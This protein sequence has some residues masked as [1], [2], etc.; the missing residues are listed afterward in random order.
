MCVPLNRHAIPTWKFRGTSCLPPGIW[1]S[2]S[3]GRPNQSGESLHIGPSIPPAITPPS[4]RHLS[5]SQA[6]S[7][8]DLLHAKLKV[9]GQKMED[10]GF[11]LEII[12]WIS[13]SDFLRFQLLELRAGWRIRVYFFHY[14]EWRISF[15]NANT[16]RGRAVICYMSS[17][18]SRGV[19]G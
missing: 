2:H 12:D 17:P 10:I 16:Q 5:F 7:Y 6:I 4:E 3:F 18:L 9:T 11:I 8:N 13:K 14:D 15:W 1:T 19:Q